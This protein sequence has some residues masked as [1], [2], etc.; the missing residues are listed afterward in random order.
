MSL[1]K[2]HYEYISPF[3]EVKASKPDESGRRGFKCFGSPDSGGDQAASVEC[4]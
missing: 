3:D 2:V 1:A 4:S